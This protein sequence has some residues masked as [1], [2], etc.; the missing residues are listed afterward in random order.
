MFERLELED[1]VLALEK[2]PI[3]KQPKDMG[4]LLENV[5]DGIR[6]DLFGRLEYAIQA[7]TIEEAYAGQAQ[8]L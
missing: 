5:P 8:Q 4:S 3:W 6:A 1:K 7:Q 2:S